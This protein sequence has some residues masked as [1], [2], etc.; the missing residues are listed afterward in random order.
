MRTVIRGERREMMF[1]RFSDTEGAVR[2][3]L[4]RDGLVCIPDIGTYELSEIRIL[5]PV[6]GLRGQHEALDAPSG[7]GAVVCAACTAKVYGA[8]CPE[9]GRTLMCMTLSEDGSVCS[10]AAGPW[11]EIPAGS[12]ADGISVFLNGK[13]VPGRAAPGRIFSFNGIAAE[14]DG[15]VVFSARAGD[16]AE[17]RSGRLGTLR[18][19]VRRGN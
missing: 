1:V 14:A 19:I 2:R 9:E 11:L 12:A 4:I 13:A 5:S 18:F 15:L 10:C 7:S 16:V 6:P 17:V 3:G 8:E